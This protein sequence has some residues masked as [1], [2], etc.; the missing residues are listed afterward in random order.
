[1]SRQAIE[2]VIRGTLSHDILAALDG[3]TVTAA[4]NGCSRVV[5]VVPD[6]AKLLG[7]LEMF[8]QLHVEVIS[9]NPVPDELS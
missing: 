4:P 6:Q 9:V 1:M 7:L 5:G 8:D 3:F 2:V